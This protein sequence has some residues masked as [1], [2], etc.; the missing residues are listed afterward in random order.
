MFLKYVGTID[1]EGKPHGKGSYYF[2]SGAEYRG[3]FKNGNF[4][5]KGMLSKSGDTYKGQF[6]ND[7]FHG[8]GIYQ[9]ADGDKVSVFQSKMR[10]RRTLVRGSIC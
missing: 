6:V 2:A 4:E 10:L 3:H 7:K 9:Y 8:V 5:G 1:E